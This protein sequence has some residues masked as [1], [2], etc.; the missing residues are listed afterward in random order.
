MPLPRSTTWQI[1]LWC[2]WDPSSVLYLVLYSKGSAFKALPL[3]GLSMLCTSESHL[4]CAH[5]PIISILEMHC[6]SPNQHTMCSINVIS[7][8]PQTLCCILVF[9]IVKYYYLCTIIYHMWLWHGTKS[10]QQFF[11]IKMIF[12]TWTHQNLSVSVSKFRSIKRLRHALH[13]LVASET[14]TAHWIPAK[15]HFQTVTKSHCQ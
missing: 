7:L 15:H 4:Q 12:V 10:D 9:S 5:I 6:K 8:W 2:T 13:S 3:F 14:I 1:A 11:T